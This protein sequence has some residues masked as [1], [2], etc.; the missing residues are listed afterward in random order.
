M[1]VAIAWSPAT[2]A[3][4]I[5][6][7]AGKIIEGD[8]YLV[9]KIELNQKQLFNIQGNFKNCWMTTSVSSPKYLGEV[10]WTM[11]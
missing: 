6:S 4:I 7:F 2:P 10:I 11:N 1:A 5:N 8:F 3:P 9:G